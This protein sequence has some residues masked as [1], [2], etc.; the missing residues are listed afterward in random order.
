MKTS[1]EIQKTAFNLLEEIQQYSEHPEYQGLNT[2][3]KTMVSCMNKIR[4]SEICG[5]KSE[6]IEMNEKSQK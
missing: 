5:E 6:A 1:E 2:A 4:V 3:A